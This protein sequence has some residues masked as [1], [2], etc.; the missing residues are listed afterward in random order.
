MGAPFYLAS[1]YEPDKWC[2]SIFM[3]RALSRITLDVL[4]VRAER[5]LDI[6]EE[7]AKAEGARPFFETFA[8]FERDQRITTGE[9]AS[10]A[11]HR[12]GF[13]VLWDEINGDRALW[14]SNPWVWVVGFRRTEPAGGR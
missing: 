2:P 7:D 11:E 13:A 4:S 1:D 14:I 3:P 9:R 10:D 6:T 12:A 8:C 5:L